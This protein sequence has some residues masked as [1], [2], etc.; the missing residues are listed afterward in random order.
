MLRRVAIAAVSFAARRAARRFGMAIAAMI[1]MI[2][3]TIISS[4]RVK[5][6]C[7]RDMSV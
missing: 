7:L 3:I 4:I 5:P 1:A 6:R 2:A